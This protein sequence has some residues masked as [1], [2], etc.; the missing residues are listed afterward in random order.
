MKSSIMKESSHD[1]EYR[2]VTMHILLEFC[3][4]FKDFSF[5]ALFRRLS[6]KNNVL[7]SAAMS[8]IFLL[9]WWLHFENEKSAKYIG[10][11]QMGIFLY[12]SRKFIKQDGITDKAMS[13]LS[14]KL[15]AQRHYEELCVA[16]FYLH[17]VVNF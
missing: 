13:A 12:F 1:E 8:V 5:Y 6:F 4:I 9:K 17:S 7:N 16:C 14:F 2:N 10:R 11:R 3:S 15:R